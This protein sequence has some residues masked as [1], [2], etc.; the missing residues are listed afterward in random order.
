MSG[1]T[2]LRMTLHNAQQGGVLLTTA[3]QWAKAML[4]AGNRLTV[5][6]HPETRK[7][8]LSRKFHKLCGDIEKSGQK[9]DGRT[10][11]KDEWKNLLVSGHAVA[12]KEHTELV[13][14]LE[15]EI[16]NIRESTA[17]MG[18]RRMASLVEYTAAYCAMNRIPTLKGDDE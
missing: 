10:F 3:V 14:G 15:G 5:T 6:M 1:T 2:K 17:R 11:S 9:F 4:T 8:S 12:T 13:D 18:T 16:V 7:E